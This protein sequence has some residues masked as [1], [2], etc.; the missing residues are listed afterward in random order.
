METLTP[1]Q[2][3]IVIAIGL[4]LTAVIAIAVLPWLNQQITERLPHT[5]TPLPTATPTRA[6]PTRTPTLQPTATPTQAEP[7]PMPS[8]VPSTTVTRV[9][10]TVTP[11]RTQAPTPTATPTPFRTQGLDLDDHDGSI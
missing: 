6:Q 1:A 2:R 5:P 3:V 10:S 9:Q 8:Q 4:A 11:A 7:T